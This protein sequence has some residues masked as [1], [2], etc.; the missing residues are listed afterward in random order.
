MRRRMGGL[1]RYLGLCALLLGLA[2]AQGA[3]LAPESQ[4]AV[5]GATFEVVLRKLDTELLTYEKPLPLEL[6]PYA[7]RSDRYWSIGTAFAIRPDTYVSAAHVLLATVGS[8]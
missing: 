8:Q 4:K 7:I 5:R 2:V 6:I 1:W 3:T